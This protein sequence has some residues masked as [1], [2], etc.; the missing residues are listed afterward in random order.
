MRGLLAA[1]FV[2]VVVAAVATV[3]LGPPGWGAAAGADVQLAGWGGELSPWGLIVGLIVLFL[4]VKL[5]FHLAA[6]PR[7]DGGPWRWHH[8]HAAPDGRDRGGPA[9]AFRRWHDEAHASTGEPDRDRPTTAAARQAPAAPSP[10]PDA[11]PRAP[12]PSQA[13]SPQYPH[14][15]SPPPQ[16]PAPGHV[17]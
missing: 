13:P 1:G 4:V 11:A 14:H 8:A 7:W 9:T 17:P 5:V 15:A 3:A 10:D 2:F 6:G 16:W 12:W